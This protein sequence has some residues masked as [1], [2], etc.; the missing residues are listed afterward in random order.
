MGLF[1]WLVPKTE[2]P[3]DP[4]TRVW[5]DRRWSWL[6]GQFGCDRLL[7]QPVVLPRPE[8]FPDPYNQRPADIYAMLGRVC[9]YMDV[10]P[11]SIS[12]SLFENDPRDP[13]RKAIGLY[14]QEGDG[15][16]IWIEVASLADPLALVAT[17]THEVGHVLLLGQE[18]ISP[19]EE[20]HE[21]LTDLLT[22]YLGMGVI[23]ANAVI[24]TTRW[25]TTSAG[26]MPM[27]TYGYA[28]ARFAR[29]RGEDGSAWVRHLRPDVR[30]AFRKAMAFLAA[31]D[32]AA[33][34]HARDSIGKG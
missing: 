25:E 15:Y 6:E 7:R 9:G 14:E 1:S 18:R 31:E 23:T 30:W 24:R 8:F 22:V 16:R 29:S 32:A 34:S 19:D 4:A 12:L 13:G 26:Y 21:P 5:V 11:S 33:L 28:L 20:D 2:C 3:I 10:D 17:F 27:R